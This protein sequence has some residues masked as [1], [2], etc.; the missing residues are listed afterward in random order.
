MNNKI[1]QFLL[2]WIIIIFISI[3]KS[4][5]Q[6]GIYRN[7]N[8]FTFEAPKS[9]VIPVG[10]T[11]ESWQIKRLEIESTLNERKI[12][13]GNLAYGMAQELH[14]CF[15]IISDNEKILRLKEAAKR[16]A[17]SLF[18]DSRGE[19]VGS[20][21]YFGM[22]L[23]ENGQINENYI[24]LD[25]YMDM[26]ITQTS[27]QEGVNICWALPGGESGKFVSFKPAGFSSPVL[28]PNGQKHPD[29]LLYDVYRGSI[30][31]RE[32]IGF[33]R[34]G[35]PV[36]QVICKEMF[37]ELRCF[38]DNAPKLSPGAPDKFYWQVS[39]IRIGKISDEKKCENLP[40]VACSLPDFSILAQ[41]LQNSTDTIQKGDLTSKSLPPPK[42]YKPVSPIT[43]LFP[44]HGIR[45]FQQMK[46]KKNKI[47]LWPLITGVWVGSGFFA[48]VSKRQSDIDY[49]I[50]KKTFSVVENE[51]S[52]NN[53]NRWH[54]RSLISAA[55]CLSVWL[56]NDTHI[57][58]KDKKA[59][60][61]SKELFMQSIPATSTSYNL[62]SE[63]LLSNQQTLGFRIKF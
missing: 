6:E 41:I 23:D 2:I 39:F 20:S 49:G 19:T 34:N 61:T 18:K 40:D 7:G 57:F 16:H 60:R 58:L 14:Q 24:H 42:A 32:R 3:F 1:I 50:H 51:W 53:A 35:M 15:R 38:L 59:R 8:K 22:V 43:Y 46:E 4:N 21:P 62:K 30:P 12:F 28:L 55:A 56:I 52:Y 36:E 31:V 45:H 63:S 25:S 47:P 27:R 48:F 54:H 10:H 13:F 9:N 11:P 33:L 44:G 17:L 29:N 5:A 26:L 37:F